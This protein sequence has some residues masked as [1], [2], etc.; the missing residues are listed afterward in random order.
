M[1]KNKNSKSILKG[2]FRFLSIIFTALLIALLLNTFVVSNTRI[3]GESMSPLLNQNDWVIVNR[4]AF[5]N[6]D[7]TFGD[8]VVLKKSDI[9]NETI[10]KRIIGTPLDTVEIKNGRLYLNGNLVENDFAQMHEN[11]NMSIITVPKNCY[12][13]MGDNTSESNDSRKWTNPFVKNDEIIGKAI[14]KYFP[15]PRKIK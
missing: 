11:E 7:P 1:E 9:T 5:L 13:V 8:V 12:F 14:F 3:I 6:C 15:K 4:L 10:I 2:N